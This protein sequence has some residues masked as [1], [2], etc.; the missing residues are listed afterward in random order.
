[1]SDRLHTFGASNKK[2]S[3]FNKATNVIQLPDMRNFS[4]AFLLPFLFVFTKNNAQNSNIPSSGSQL[5]ERIGTIPQDSIFILAKQLDSTEKDTFFQTYL[6]ILQNGSKLD[7]MMWVAEQYIQATDG[8]PLAKGNYHYWEGTKYQFET[9]YDSADASY[10]KA[11]DIYSKAKEYWFLAST[12]ANIAGNL[13]T[14]GKYD[15]GI[16]ALYTGL[17]WAEKS[18]DMDKQISIKSN[19]ANYLAAAKKDYKRALRLLDETIP[20]FEAKKDTNKLA[21]ALKSKGIAL[22]NSKLYE[23]AL[24]THQRALALYRSE[25]NTINQDEVLFHCGNVLIK[26]EQYNE[27][28]DTMRKVERN[29]MNSS[30]KQGLPYTRNRLGD[31]LFKLGRYDEAEEYLLEN[32]ARC[33]QRK[34]YNTAAKASA[35]L[36]TIYK[37][38]G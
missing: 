23:E 19:L 24:A 10:R 7:S 15:E 33:E 29:L 18:G 6:T 13:A 28:L 30:N 31:I 11:L 38:Q 4:I 9:K 5:F 22:M 25:N 12:Y 35:R 20:Y 37:A 14:S 21:Y 17:E 32:F 26:M 8:S 27:A 1:L 3:F 36:A 2:Q 16:A 34:Q